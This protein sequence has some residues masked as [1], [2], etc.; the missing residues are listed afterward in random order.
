MPVAL[1]YDSDTS[2]YSGSECDS[3]C[4]C[5]WCDEY[6]LDYDDSRDGVDGKTYAF[7]A[8]STPINWIE[9]L[10]AKLTIYEQ[11]HGKRNIRA[12]DRLLFADLVE[13][14]SLL[15][16]QVPGNTKCVD[17]NHWLDDHDQLTG[18]FSDDVYVRSVQD[19]ATRTFS[20]DDATL[21]VMALLRRV[22]HVL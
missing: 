1:D 13:I 17:A 10:Q 11:A 12:A 14:T 19:Y 16:Q 4:E 9:R 21:T 3:D 2:S 18:D 15:M 5:D 7:R 8:F 6:E 22:M 20:V